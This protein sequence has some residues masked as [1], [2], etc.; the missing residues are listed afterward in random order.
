[1]PVFAITR[2]FS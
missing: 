1:V 2:E